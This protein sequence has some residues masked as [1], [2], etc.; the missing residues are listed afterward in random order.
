MKPEAQ[1]KISRDISLIDLLNS[2]DL[3]REILLCLARCGPAG[4]ATLT[5][6]TSLD[7]TQVQESLAVLLEEGRVRPLTNGQVEAVIGRAKGRAT[8]PARLWHAL[9]TTDRLYSEQDI[10][11]LRTVGLTDQEQAVAHGLLKVIYDS[12]PANDTAGWGAV[13]TLILDQIQADNRGY[14]AEQAAGFVATYALPA[15]PDRVEGAGSAFS[16]KPWRVSP[17]LLLG[18]G[19]GNRSARPSA[20]ARYQLQDALRHRHLA[21]G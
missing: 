10:A 19:G 1:E 17:C 6:F 21:R 9:L 4:F 8:L 2:S 15:N 12:Q 3:Q 18:F 5:Q 11:T 14:F 20:R 7:P 16:A 13:A